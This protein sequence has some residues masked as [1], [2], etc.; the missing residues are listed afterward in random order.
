MNDIDW[1][2][3][4]EVK[5]LAAKYPKILIKERSE[6]LKRYRDKHKDYF[7]EYNKKHKSKLLEQARIRDR[8]KRAEERIKREEEARIKKMTIKEYLEENKSNS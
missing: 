1:D 5:K 4:E 7:K 6:T 8:R 3:P 2:N